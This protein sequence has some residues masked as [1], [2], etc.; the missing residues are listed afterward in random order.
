MCSLCR[1]SLRSRTRPGKGFSDRIWWNMIKFLSKLVL[2]VTIPQT[3]FA[4]ICVAPGHADCQIS[5]PAECIAQYVEPKGPCSTMCSPPASQT[6]TAPGHPECTVTCTGS[7]MA[8]FTEP[9]G[10]CNA[11]CTGGALSL[12]IG[13]LRI[14]TREVG[15]SSQRQR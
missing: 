8:L 2:A 12:S 3:G 14:Q 4:E 10:P 9:D 6:C 1:G 13:R 15:P 11:T 5:C 7:C